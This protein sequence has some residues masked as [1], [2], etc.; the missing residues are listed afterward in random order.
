MF[1]LKDLSLVIVIIFI[2]A[3]VISFSICK[4]ITSNDRI[5]SKNKIEP[6]LRMC[7]GESFKMDTTYIYV[8]N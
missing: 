8:K 5:E 2:I 3:F 6:T 4:I 1:K 7:V